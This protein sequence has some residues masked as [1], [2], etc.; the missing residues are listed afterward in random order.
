MSKVLRYYREFR[1]VEV[2]GALLQAY[3]KDN[4]TFSL[5]HICSAAVE[6]V[7]ER[8]QEEGDTVLSQPYQV[9]LAVGTLTWSRA[10]K[11]WVSQNYANDCRSLGLSAVQTF[12]A[13]WASFVRMFLLLE[14]QGS[15]AR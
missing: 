4:F 2:L 14:L 7:K 11:S 3:I 13:S 9:C 12:V 10:Q 1:V 6:G 15:I 5:I 8:E